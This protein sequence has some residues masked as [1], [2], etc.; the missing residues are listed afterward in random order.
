M[1]GTFY[2]KDARKAEGATIVK[3]LRACADYLRDTDIKDMDEMELQK[4]GGDIY[5]YLGFI[6][7]AFR[8][9]VYMTPTIIKELDSLPSI[10]RLDP[11]CEE[12]RYTI[13]ELRELSK[14]IDDLKPKLVNGGCL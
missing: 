1:N 7:H 6:E 10:E 9:A 3:H 14:L 8:D 12:K 13:Q 11:T 5:G 4:L 2:T